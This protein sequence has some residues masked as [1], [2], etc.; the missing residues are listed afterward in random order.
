LTVAVAR[1]IGQNVCSTSTTNLHG[2]L[3]H[4]VLRPMCGF[5]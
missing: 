4:K 2:V 1:H 3:G 5:R